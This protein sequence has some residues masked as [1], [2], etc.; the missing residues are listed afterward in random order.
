MT[1]EIIAAPLLPLTLLVPAAIAA[2]AVALLG[3]WAGSRAAWTRAGVLGA[4]ILVLINPSAREEERDPVPDTAVIVVDRSLS[5]KIAGRDKITGTALAKLRE[6][7]D[8]SENLE[9]RIVE[10]GESHD[11]AGGDG[12]EL[13]AA[14]RSAT[15]GISPD[16][17]AGVVVVT[18]GQVHDVPDTAEALGF[19]APVHTLLTGRPEEADR[20]LTIVR[21]PR[22]GIVGE[23][24]TVTLRVDDSG[25]S[26]STS[27]RVEMR[28]DGAK[29]QEFNIVT[30]RDHDLRFE[31]A[32]GGNNVIEIEVEDGP[33]ELT[34]INNRAVIAVNGIRDRLRVLL[35][36]GEPHAGERTWRN[37]LKAD[38]S[39][40][41][42]HFTILRP[43]EKLHMAP[44]QELSLIEFPVRELFDEK[45]YDFDLIIF[46]RYQRRRVLMPKYFENMAR[47]VEKGGAL[48]VAAGPAFSGQASIYRSALAG[49]LPAQPSG[50][51]LTGGFAPMITEEGARHPVTAALAGS[52]IGP[53]GA[54][55][56]PQWGRWFRLIGSQKLSG[57][58]LM[59][60]PRDQPLLVLDRVGEGRVAQ[61]MSDH[62]WLWTRGFEDGGPQAELLRRLAHWLMKEPDLE[63]EDLRA[64]SRGDR[65]E[66]RRRMRLQEF[67]EVFQ[68]GRGQGSQLAPEAGAVIQQRIRRFLG[69]VVRTPLPD[70]GRI[71]RH[72]RR[73]QRAQQVRRDRRTG[74]TAFR[75]ALLRIGGKGRKGLLVPTVRRTSV[76]ELEI[77]E[78]ALNR[79]NMI[80]DQRRLQN[81]IGDARGRGNHQHP[82]VHLQQHAER[83]ALAGQFPA[84]VQALVRV[85]HALTRRHLCVGK[86]GVVQRQH[87]LARGLRRPAL[88]HRAV[89]P[90]QRVA[91][92]N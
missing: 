71:V 30:G 3:L 83:L 91:E 69:P 84:P 78:L 52:G 4:L 21:A 25:V 32:H 13:F 44:V 17:V 88:A 85:L 40:D 19:D 23:T 62:A 31:L 80:G 48:L 41:L 43:M 64:E 74:E 46:D 37:L 90:G 55:G 24:L 28:V 26:G 11:G 12:T 56:K 87:G 82:A 34:R 86:I 70:G 54:V 67:F 63:E 47:F 39:V 15:S 18:D 75:P 61:L 36:S 77:L 51:V 65:L 50:K 9:L 7:L 16:A 89:P 60:G 66:V 76:E 79:L 68:T 53:E 92:R 81:E 14:L 35:V 6:K 58:K 8:A 42:V 27:A 29:T 38:P 20:R 22:F 45:L 73:C 10:A 57:R 33:A 5:Q 1:W 2:L 72:E 49:I 59:T